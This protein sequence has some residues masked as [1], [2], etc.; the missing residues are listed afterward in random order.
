[1]IYPAKNIIIKRCFDAYIRFIVTRNFSKINFNNLVIDKSKPVLLIAN[2]SGFWDGFL[3][4]YVNSQL[5]KKKFHVMLLEQTAKRF[6]LFKY[7]GA[8]SINKNS[9]DVVHSLNFAAQLLNNPENLVLIF[10]Q[11][12]LYSNFIT[13]V[14]FEKGVMK[15]MEKAQDKFQLIYSAMFIEYFTNKKPQVNIYLKH[16]TD[17]AFKNIQQLQA[18]YQH[19]YD[20]ARN[21]QTQIV[22]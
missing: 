9:K 20:D 14:E 4:Q 18:D 12:K 5:F 22:I 15:V 16:V 21:Q 6:P 13:K 7:A 11:G 8:F 17:A 10:P 3:I 2:H 19:H 1:M